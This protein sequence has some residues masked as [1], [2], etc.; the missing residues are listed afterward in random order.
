MQ[1]K[2]N[3]QKFVDEKNKADRE[4]IEGAK[5]QG[6]AGKIS[7]LMIQGK[8]GLENTGLLDTKKFSGAGVKPK[9]KKKYPDHKLRLKAKKMDVIKTT[10]PNKKSGGFAVLIPILASLATEGISQLIQYFAKK[11]GSG[12]TLGTAKTK[13]EQINELLKLPTADVKKAISI[14]GLS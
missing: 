11:S 12:V 10:K 1:N 14:L 7:S 5:T 9:G 6:V 2:N 4:F 13:T 3:K 8:M